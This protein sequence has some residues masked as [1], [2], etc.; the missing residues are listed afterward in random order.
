MK[1]I[2]GIIYVFKNKEEGSPKKIVDLLEKSIQSV[3]SNNKEA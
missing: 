1:E 3:K 2:N